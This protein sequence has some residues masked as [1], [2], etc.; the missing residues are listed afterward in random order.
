MSRTFNRIEVAALLQ[1]LCELKIKFSVHDAGMMQVFILSIICPCP[2]DKLRR[3]SMVAYDR[4]DRMVSSGYFRPVRGF[5]LCRNQCQLDVSNCCYGIDAF[6]VLLNNIHSKSLLDGGTVCSFGFPL[7][8]E[9]KQLADSGI[10]HMIYFLYDEPEAEV[11]DYIG[12]IRE[13]VAF[14]FEQYSVPPKT[15]E[16]FW[17]IISGDQGLLEAMRFEDIGLLLAIVSSKQADCKKQQIGCAAFS[18]E[19]DLVGAGHNSPIV[20]DDQC[21]RKGCLLPN[22]LCGS[23]S[24]VRNMLTG[25]SIHRDL[26]GGTI[27]LTHWPDFESF[28]LLGDNGVKRIVFFGQYSP[29]LAEDDESS[30]ELVSIRYLA[31]AIGMG[32]DQY[33]PDGSIKRVC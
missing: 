8:D 26:S 10:R 24:A 1:E 9:I 31:H 7:G 19:Q 17:K 14:S 32:L 11:L 20:G 29:I 12:V 23:I 27:F 16:S 5:A 28:K 13:P 6:S 15:F 2:L 18:S 30:D 25:L 3:A 22:K 33:G 4:N 21:Q